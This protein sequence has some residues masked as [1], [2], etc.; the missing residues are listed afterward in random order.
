MEVPFNQGMFLYL[1]ESFSEGASEAAA[2]FTLINLH[3]APQSDEARFRGL[4]R[5][6]KN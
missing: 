3:F 5:L 4:L 2:D 1:L 6:S